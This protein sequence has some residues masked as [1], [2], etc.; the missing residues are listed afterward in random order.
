MKDFI[1]QNVEYRDLFDDRGRLVLDDY[2]TMELA[3]GWTVDGKNDLFL[4]I[5]NGQSTMILTASIVSEGTAE[6]ALAAS[7]DGYLADPA[8]EVTELVTFATDAGG[9]GATYR[10]VLAVTPDTGSGFWAVTQNG[11]IMQPVAT[12]PGDLNDPL[13]A[14]VDQMVRTIEISA[15]PAEV[16]P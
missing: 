8:N 10:A 3:D 5:A 2:T 16:S 6:E 1:E 15:E 9:E 11:R 13:Y 7:R 14:E 4:T 12:G